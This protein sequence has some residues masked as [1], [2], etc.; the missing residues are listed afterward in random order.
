MPK[1]TKTATMK[2]SG[3]KAGIADFTI[4]RT[5]AY[6]LGHKP[7]TRLQ[8]ES[9][10]FPYLMVTCKGA[11]TQYVGNSTGPI[12]DLGVKLLKSQHRL[13]VLDLT[14]LTLTSSDEQV[15]TFTFQVFKPLV[16]AGKRVFIVF[17]KENYF[18]EIYR[19]T[20][21]DCVYPA[22]GSVEDLQAHLEGLIMKNPEGSPVKP[23]H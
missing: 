2:A 1:A 13:I 16:E 20:K 15:F 23:Q 7:V 14:D 10:T 9:L 12:S 11:L 17:R 6:P 19:R 3:Q 8:R 18:S 21:L 22:Y 4:T 5:R